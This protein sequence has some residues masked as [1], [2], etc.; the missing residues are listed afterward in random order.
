MRATGIIYNIGTLATAYGNEKKCGKEQGDIK[1]L[2]DAYVAM[3]GASIIAVGTGPA[4][5]ELIGAGTQ[6]IDA[7]GRL[8][9][10]GLVDSHTHLVFGG[11]RE[12]ELAQKLHG[13]AYLDILNAGGGIHSTVK[14]TRGSTEDELYVKAKDALMHM[15]VLGTT[16][17]EAK[18]GYGLSYDDELKQ[19]RVAERLNDEG[20]VEIV[21]TFMGAHAVPKEYA[22]NR[23]AYISLLTERLIP[24]VARLG[25][26]RYCDVFCETAVFTSKESEAILECAQSY[27]LGAKI[28]ADEIDAIGGS[29]VAGKLHAISAEHLIA[30]TDSGIS[31][32]ADGGT[33]A[34]LLPATSFYL[35]KEFAPAN[36]M[37][38]AGVAVAVASDFN[39][40]STPNLSLQL[41]M[42]IACYK[43]RMTPEEVL[44]A[45]TLN[46]AAAIGLPDKLGTVEPGKQADL[47]IWDAPN[48]DRI[49]YRYGSNQVS[50]VIK[51][52]EIVAMDGTVIEKG[53]LA[54]MRVSDFIE[55]VASS[56][57]APGGGSVSAVAGAMGIGLAA[58]T[59]KLTASKKKYA[60]VHELMHSIIERA[61]PFVSDMTQG[62]DKDTDAYNGFGIAAKLPKETDEQKAIRK[63]AMQNALKQAAQIPFELLLNCERALEILSEGVGTIN[64]N[65][66]SDLGS[67]AANLRSA[68]QGAWLNVLINI[69]GIEDAEFAAELR[70]KGEAAIKHCYELADDAF[71]KIEKYIVG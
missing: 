17:V 5:Q 2:H 39:P 53:R 25:L 51:K 1:Q 54:D 47:L 61:D 14:A 12:H 57:P 22:N 29:E 48:L 58:M 41:P 20:P 55:L 62:I 69:G 65:C 27:G 37:I 63:E 70:T 44:T 50:T 46:A 24:E 59:A 8:V 34:V 11:W 56:E 49:F 38:D 71:A 52:G 40:G 4:P 23:E 66:Y 18:S 19:L 9:T 6:L 10:A 13:V 68:A 60:D 16:T 33:V 28:H 45:V 7:D 3:D 31:A 32:L 26:A 15:L 30:A 35:D 64:P 43:Y 67:G 42:N 21:S 36:K